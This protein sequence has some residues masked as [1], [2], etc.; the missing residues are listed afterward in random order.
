MMLTH[1]PHPSCSFHSQST[2]SV[3]GEGQRGTRSGELYFPPHPPQAVPLSHLSVRS[4]LL[5]AAEVFTEDPRP[6]R[7]RL[8]LRIYL[9][10]AGIYACPTIASCR[11]PGTPGHRSLRFLPQARFLLL[12]CR[13]R[14]RFCLRQRSPPETRDPLHDRGRTAAA[15]PVG[16]KARR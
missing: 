8:M 1:S 11:L 5:P 9:N 10:P 16:D 13:L 12:A 15:R 6:S 7:G 14:H 3:P 4:A 2:L